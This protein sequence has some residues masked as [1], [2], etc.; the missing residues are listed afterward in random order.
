M[1]R[2][3]L[4]V[5]ASG[6]ALVVC[7]PLFLAI[8]AA[9]K[10]GSPGPVL[11]RARRVGRGGQLFTLYKF[12]TMG[13]GAHV[14]G[15]PI[16]AEGDS[17]VTPVGRVLRQWKLD[18]L[19]QLYNVLRGD[20]SLVGP[21]P[22]DPMYVADYTDEQRR[23]LSVRPGLTSPATLAYRHEAA[24]LAAADDPEVTY[25]E[26]VLPAKLAIE[27]DYLRKRTLFLDLLILARTVRA[28]AR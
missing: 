28:L 3:T 17:R 24:V 18:E 8:A 16:T 11:Y 23:L 26:V 2:R 9:V 7:A 6:T 14:S 21:R 10:I 27:L 5:V 12:R 1:W 4:D 13:P 20:M 19:P 15:P 25:R 22:E